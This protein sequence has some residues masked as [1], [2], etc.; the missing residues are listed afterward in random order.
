MQRKDETLSADSVNKSHTWEEQEQSLYTR[1]AC[2]EEDIPE[3]LWRVPSI[4]VGYFLSYFKNIGKD[5]FFVGGG[6]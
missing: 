5:I 3:T 4:T 1:A 2:C 6:R